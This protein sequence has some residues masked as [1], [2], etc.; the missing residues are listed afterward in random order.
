MP[1][2]KYRYQ[3]QAPKLYTSTANRNQAPETE[4]G[5]RM[6]TTD[7]AVI[8]R[9]FNELPGEGLFMASFEDEQ[10]GGR[11]LDKV[12]A[13]RRSGLDRVQ[14]EA[15]IRQLLT[16]HLTR[17]IDT[18]G[19]L[20][21][22][23]SSIEQWVKREETASEVGIY[24]SPGYQL[25]YIE[26]AQKAQGELSQVRD[27]LQT[28]KDSIIDALI[29]GLF[30]PGIGGEDMNP[31]AVERLKSYIPVMQHDGFMDML[32]NLPAVKSAESDMFQM[33]ASL[34]TE[35]GRI[36]ISPGEGETLSALLANVSDSQM[37]L[38]CYSIYLYARQPGDKVR[39]NIKDYF[40]QRGITK[41][42][43]NVNK[44]MEDLHL[45]QRMYF[46][47]DAQVS[48]KTEKAKYSRVLAIT[49]IDTRRNSISF[50]FGDWIKTLSPRQYLNIHRSFFGYIASN[51]SPYSVRLSLKLA[52]R[53]HNNR[54]KQQNEELLNVGNIIDYLGFNEDTIRERGFTAACKEKI[55]NT[56]DLIAE[57]EGY[58]WRY[59]QGQHETYEQYRKDYIIFSNKE[60]ASL[61][62]LPSTKR[63]KETPK[64]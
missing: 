10:D 45:L 50:A 44:L 43:K 13:I 22:V 7:K 3:Y 2:T 26:P 48:G 56:L 11:V 60:R 34:K 15:I 31:A 37:Q 51:D 18:L 16:D 4:G 59:K 29:Q 35:K 19:D 49:D 6:E 9:I 28:Q 32:L 46:T 54:A 40:E 1:G 36:D 23:T 55:T 57:K 20:W 41:Q 8:E 52:Q 61:F 38:L 39:L 17:M 14:Q 42:S 24:L 58:K 63:E 5:R 33:A 30:A 21:A 12:L 53:I 25:S 47:F 62:G 64:R 27:I